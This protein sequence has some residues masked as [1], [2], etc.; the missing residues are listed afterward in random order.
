[1]CIGVF[2]SLML[3][4]AVMMPMM[5]IMHTMKMLMIVV[6]VVMVEDDGNYDNDADDK[7]VIV[8]DDDCEKY[9]GNDE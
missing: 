5:K 1:M 8:V 2:I 4:S 7:M 9:G 6:V 3:C